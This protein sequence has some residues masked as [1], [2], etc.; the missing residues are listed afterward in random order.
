MILLGP[1]SKRKAM[2]CLFHVFPLHLTGPPSVSQKC[3]GII[4]GGGVSEN[5][6]GCSSESVKIVE[7]ILGRCYFR[8]WLDILLCK[9]GKPN[10][11]R[12]VL[13][14]VSSDNEASKWCPNLCYFHFLYRQGGF[15]YVLTPC[16][17]CCLTFDLCIQCRP[18]PRRLRGVL[19]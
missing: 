8:I 1:C 17:P 3:R 11:S 13:F 14:L 15:I 18:L 16:C 12:P 7:C 5:G 9:I 6:L 4:Q 19:R 10:M 2:V